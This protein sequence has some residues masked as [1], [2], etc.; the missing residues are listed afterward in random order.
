M[1]AIFVPNRIP[2]PMLRPA[3]LERA[4]TFY[5]GAFCMHEM[6]RETF[7]EGAF[8]LVFIGYGN[9]GSDALTELT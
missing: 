4:L 1:T 3:D 6:R 5:R 8:T 9:A 7:P 2:D